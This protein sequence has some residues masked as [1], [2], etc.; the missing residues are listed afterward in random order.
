MSKPKIAVILGSTRDTRFS[1][2]PGQWILDLAKARGDIEVELVDPKDYD[3]PF[4]NEPASD[5]WMPSQDPH[6]VA[7]QN[8]I[9]SFDGF[10]FVVAEYNHS[11]PGVL[12]NA[13]DQA[14]KGWMRKPAAYL[15]YG[16][17]GG[18]RA[19]EHL[20]GICVELQMVPVRSAVHIGGGEYMKVWP[21]AGNQPM[22]AIEE[23]ILPS[24]KDMLNQLVWWTHTTKYGRENIQ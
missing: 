10:I 20:R 6:A 9:G 22:S 15:G 24:A 12:K 14:Y 7:W 11:I 4:F 19:V 13:L 21:M 8:K 17:V 1:P 18:A 23:V 16:G 3:L 2:V 5:L